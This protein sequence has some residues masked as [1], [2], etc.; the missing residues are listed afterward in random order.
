MAFN[1]LD[2]YRVFSHRGTGSTTPIKPPILL[3]PLFFVVPSTLQ[4]H[5]LFIYSKRNRAPLL[6]SPQ[7]QRNPSLLTLPLGS[8]SYPGKEPSQGG[9]S[10]SQLS[11]GFLMRCY[12]SLLP[13]FLVL[14]EISTIY[15]EIL[16]PGEI[17]ECLSGVLMSFRVFLRD[18]LT[19]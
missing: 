2:L 17:I 18:D 9:I 5:S 4:S 11:P 6:P 3:S 14:V 7:Y 10:E 8:S 12:F 16:F 1:I 19:E 13:S 15:S